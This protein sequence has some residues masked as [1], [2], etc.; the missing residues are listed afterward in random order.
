MPS[1]IPSLEVREARHCSGDIVSTPT[2]YGMDISFQ[3][4]C[5]YFRYDMCVK[6]IQRD[7]ECKTPCTD[8]ITEQEIESLIDQHKAYESPVPEGYYKERVVV[9]RV[10]MYCPCVDPEYGWTPENPILKCSHPDNKDP[11]HECCLDGRSIPN[12]C[13]LPIATREQYDLA[14]PDNFDEIE[15]IGKKITDGESLKQEG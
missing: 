4:N 13:P 15:R 12:H 1:I 2:D 11:D 6:G 10:G 8:H 9:V 14:F 5:T 7:M 3:N